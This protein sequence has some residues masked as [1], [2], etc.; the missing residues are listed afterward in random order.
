MKKIIS[1]LF[2]I[3]IFLSFFCVAVSAE[4]DGTVEGGYFAVSRGEE[5]YFPVKYTGHS[6]VAVIRIFVDY[7][8][9]KLEYIGVKRTADDKMK[10]ADTNKNGRI[11]LLLDTKEIANITDDITLFEAVFRVKKEAT[12]GNVKITLSGDAG[13]YTE[14]NTNVESVN[15]KFISGYIEVICKE[16]SFEDLEDGTQKCKNCGASKVGDTI[17]IPVIEDNG[18]VTGTIIKDGEETHFEENQSS[19]ETDEPNKNE[20]TQDDENKSL[21]E[22]TEPNKN[23]D[24]KDDENKIGYIIP[25][26][27]AVIIAAGIII[28]VLFINKKKK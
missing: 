12:V 6:G 28:T 24:T 8:T 26:V 17:K 14:N 16:H 19:G 3:C 15:P 7:D 9:E 18:N 21:L 23:E 27:A 20:D 13:K 4:G 5:I 11:T 10:Y 1:L 2:I 22:V 25:L